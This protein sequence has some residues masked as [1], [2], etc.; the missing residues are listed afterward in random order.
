MRETHKI[1]IVV[2]DIKTPL[3]ATDRTHTKN[4]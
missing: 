1:I 2:E 4:L 3:S